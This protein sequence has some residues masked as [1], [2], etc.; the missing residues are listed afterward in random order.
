MMSDTDN[1]KNISINPISTF[2]LKFDLIIFCKNVLQNG[3]IFD[4]T[5]LI[6]NNLPAWFPERLLWQ[7][8]L[9]NLLESDLPLP[10]LPN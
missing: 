5:G 1:G 9:S 10:W 2:V 6:R 4:E 8:L 3:I 7:L